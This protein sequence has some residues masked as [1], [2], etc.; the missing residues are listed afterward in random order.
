[1]RCGLERREPLQKCKKKRM[2]GDKQGRAREK[3]Q[4][5]I[6][7]EERETATGVTGECCSGS[8]GK[9]KADRRKDEEVHLYSTQD[10]F[11]TLEGKSL[12]LYSPFTLSLSAAHFIL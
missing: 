1:M 4:E 6:D 2:T 8:D 7:N 9:W 10:S 3:E 11:F 12:S 5:E